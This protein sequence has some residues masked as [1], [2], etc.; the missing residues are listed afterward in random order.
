MKK[1]NLELPKYR[2]QLHMKL[3][4][5]RKPLVAEPFIPTVSRVKRKYHSGSIVGRFIRYVADHKNAK[6]LL[7]S[8]LAV[9]AIATAAVPSAGVNNVF[10]QTEESTIQAENTLSTQKALQYPLDHY[11]INQGYNFFHPGLDLGAGVGEPIKPIKSGVVIE[12]EFTKSGYGNTVLIDHGKG[13]TSRYA[14]LSVIEVKKGDEVLTSKEIGK[15]G[16]TGRSTGPHLHLEIRQNG[17][18]LNPSSVI[19]K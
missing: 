13:L 4:K 7:A 3:V 19:P 18:P 16:I 1:F 8:N 14:H 11:K 5:R 10:A 9:V 2:L 17:I 6:R 15:V 12:A